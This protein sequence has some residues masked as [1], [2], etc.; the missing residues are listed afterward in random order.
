MTAC[1]FIPLNIH[2]NQR[3]ATCNSYRGKGVFNAWGNSFPAEEVPFGEVVNLGGVQFALPDFKNH[4]PDHV[5]AAAQKVLFPI[6]CQG[7]GLGVLCCGE[8]GNQTLG[9]K[10]QSVHS[11]ELSF[12]CEAGPWLID[13]RNPQPPNCLA[14]SHLHYPGDYELAHLCPALWAFTIA[15]GKCLKTRSLTLGTN[16]LFH[17]FA[18]T[19]LQEIPCDERSR[20]P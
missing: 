5:E 17:I 16:P 20:Q 19:L 13:P 1:H 9:I 8:M 7:N 12:R 6:D 4:Q 18:I 10:L 14:F 2:L 3:S 11:E 15:L